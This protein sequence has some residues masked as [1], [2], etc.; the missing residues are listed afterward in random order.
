MSKQ[1]KLIALGI[2][3][4]LITIGLLAW[5]IPKYK[6][7]Q[8]E[9]R[10]KADLKEA[11][12]NRQ[13]L[14]EEANAKKESAKLLA[15]AEVIRA[16]GI[17]EANK[18]IAGS[19]TESYLKYRFIE[20]LQTNNMQTIYVPVDGLVPVFDYRRTESNENL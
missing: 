20:G 5:G 6:I 16:G 8:K 12:W 1:T 18:I 11:E 10:G 13:I 3:I 14:I 7:Y 9:L 4:G 17:A 15:E 19:I 2:I